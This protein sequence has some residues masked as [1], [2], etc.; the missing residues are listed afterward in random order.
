MT[1]VLRTES[2]EKR[3]DGLVATDAVTLSVEAGEVHA[4]IGPNG[5]GKTTLINQLTGEIRPDSGRIFFLG[6][7]VTH[8]STAQRARR[9]LARSYQISQVFRDL[10]VTEN[11]LIAAQARWNHCFRFWR[12]AASDP[13]LNEAGVKAL[14]VV[15]LRGRDSVRVAA[16]AHGEVRQLELAMAL[17]SKP[18]V[19]LLDEPMAG[20]STA[21]SERIVELLRSVKGSCGILLVEHD[22]NAVFALADR[23]TVLAN[24]SVIAS[25]SIDEIRRDQA[26]REAYLGDEAES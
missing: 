15:G 21:E 7:E 2:L 20:M 17:A 19:L 12:S 1:A 25:G 9:G 4:V 11:M 23:A 5:A 18:R 16:L 10:T 26:V 6:E 14:E 22:M 3:F 8:E 13:E 24:G